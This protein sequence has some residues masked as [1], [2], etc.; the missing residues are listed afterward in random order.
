METEKEKLK[1]LEE[2]YSEVKR[3]VRN[4]GRTNFLTVSEIDELLI[5][6]GGKE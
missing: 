3:K 4:V 2:F 5:K 1:R 6:Y